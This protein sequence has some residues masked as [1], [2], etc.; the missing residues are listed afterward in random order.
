MQKNWIGRSEG[1]KL[2]FKID[3]QPTLAIFNENE[4]FEV[5][6]IGFMI[7][8]EI[9]S[10]SRIDYMK[11][12]LQMIYG[13]SLDKIKYKNQRYCVFPLNI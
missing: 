3:Q 7:I 2:K 5:N 11:D 6:E 12:K 13:L 1:L 4:K 8:G 10:K 9:V